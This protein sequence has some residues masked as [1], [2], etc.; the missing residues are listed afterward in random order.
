MRELSFDVKVGLHQW[1]VLSPLLFAVVMDVVSSEQEVA[2]LPS[3]CMLM[4]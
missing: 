1:S 3:F 4:T 2:C